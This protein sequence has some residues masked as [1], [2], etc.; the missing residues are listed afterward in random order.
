MSSNPVPSK[1][2]TVIKKSI[3]NSKA[4]KQ[5]FLSSKRPIKYNINSYLIKEYGS[6]CKTKYKY[7]YQIIENLLYKKNTH[8]VSEFKDQIILDITDEYLKKFYAKKESFKKIPQYS[9]FYILY[10]IYFCIPTFRTVFFNRIIHQQREKKAGCF[11]YEH[12]KENINANS[13]NENN[14][15]S[16]QMNNKL[17]REKIINLKNKKIKNN[18]T[19]FNKE[20]E[21]ILDKESKNDIININSSL[22]IHE[23]G[24]KLKNSRSY[25]L[26]N[27]S[28][29]ES[30]CNIINTIYKKNYS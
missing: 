16:E 29:E 23:S 26:V 2:S 22:S 9:K 8:Y 7:F 11:Y 25:L 4:T 24:S 28:N 14:I 12:F 19:F 13:S 30:L 21:A 1:L 18:K 3:S 5:P 27:N 15:E 10:Q 6:N 20:V 17:D